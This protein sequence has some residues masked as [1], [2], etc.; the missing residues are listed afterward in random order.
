M[1]LLLSAAVAALAMSATIAA[2][3][4]NN[5]PVTETRSTG[6]NGETI[7]R[8]EACGAVEIITQAPQTPT[9]T[10]TTTTTRSR[11]TTTTTPSN[12]PSNSG[13]TNTSGG[14]GGIAPG[15]NRAPPLVNSSRDTIMNGPPQGGAGGWNPANAPDPMAMHRPMARIVL[16]D[17]NN[18]RGRNIGITQNTPDLGRRRFSDIASAAR[19]QGGV[20]ELCSEP[21]YGGACVTTDTDLVLAAENMNDTVASVRLV[22]P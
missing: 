21:N 12:A 2:Q 1:R 6:P 11:T 10:T 7:I 15:T 18:F 19:S 9:T 16:Y 22:R 8:R 14:G 17:N 13:A 5:C 4:Q 20:W 3:A